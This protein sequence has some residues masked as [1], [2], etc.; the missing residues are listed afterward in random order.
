MK[1][2]KQISAELDELKEELDDLEHLEWTDL[3]TGLA[4]T[5]LYQ[6]IRDKEIWIK[7][8]ESIIY[9]IPR[10]KDKRRTPNLNKEMEKV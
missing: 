4:R 9:N 5:R 6:D 2:R 10:V 1:T 8:Y 3:V 7:A